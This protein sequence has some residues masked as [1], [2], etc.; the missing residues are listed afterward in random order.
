[1]KAT[2]IERA[3]ANYTEAERYTGLSR[4][5]L[6]RGLRSGK[7]KASGRGRGIRFRI[8]DLDEF[9]SGRTNRD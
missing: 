8:S 4:T 6:W 1:M 9:M 3:Y 7:L 2:T 5:T